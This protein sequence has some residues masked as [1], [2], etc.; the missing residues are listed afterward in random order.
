RLA[1][2][3]V[4]YLGRIDFQVKIRGFRIELGEIEAR[5]A[6]P[7]AVRD[8]IVIARE[9]TPGEKRLVAYYTLAESVLEAPTAETL[10]TH[11]L[12]Q[13]P[14]YMAPAAYIV[15]DALPLTG[16]GK[17]DRKALPAPDSQAL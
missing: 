15:L 12:Q 16:N 4:D 7:P 14:D 6:S 2:G 11:L 9:D 8:A 3:S 13:L 10:R 5:L 1:D 17:L